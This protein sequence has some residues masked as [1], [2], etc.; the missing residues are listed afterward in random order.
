ML[1]FNFLSNQN[2]DMTKNRKI[3]WLIAAVLS[4]CALNS[5]AKEHVHSA[6]SASHVALELT[7]KEIEVSGVS[8]ST[9]TPVSKT[10]AVYLSLHNISEGSLV[11]EG[12]ETDA[13]HHGMIHKTVLEDGVAKM[14]HMDSIEIKS[15]GKLEFVQGGL[16]IMLMG[17][18]KE[19][20]VKEFK[21]NLVFAG[22][23]RFEVI[24]NRGK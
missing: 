23:K 12:V 16:H 1:S 10:A 8:L 7:E 22:E 21:L 15:G 5:F 24:V 9:I 19:K 11:L 6:E 14:R 13:A 4:T 18:N 3:N 2:K 17:L 20:M